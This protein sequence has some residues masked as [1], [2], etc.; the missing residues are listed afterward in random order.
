[1]ANMQAPT[2]GAKRWWYFS[3]YARLG[4]HYCEVAT[5]KATSLSRNGCD[6]SALAVLAGC[7]IIYRWSAGGVT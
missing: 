5:A 3:S 4:K 1:M 2:L 7:L 6:A